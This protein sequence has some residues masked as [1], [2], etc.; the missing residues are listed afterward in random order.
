MGSAKWEYKRITIWGTEGAVM[1]DQVSRTL[2]R[3][4]GEAGWE[5]VSA[6]YQPGEGYVYFFKRLKAGES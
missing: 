4:F 6:F 2:S 5:L 1:D 3:E